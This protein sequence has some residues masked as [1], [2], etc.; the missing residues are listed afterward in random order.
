MAEDA[1]RLAEAAQEVTDRLTEIASAAET[2]AASGAAAD[3][4][5]LDWV[6][7]TASLDPSNISGMAAAS[8]A[9]ADAAVNADAAF[10]DWATSTAA[11]A[12]GV[13]SVDELA[14]AT[15]QAEAAAASAADAQSGLNEATQ[16][17]ADAAN[18]ASNSW[19]EL[20]N[21]LGD[22][23]AAT[24]VVAGEL[25]EL[26]D[27]VGEHLV[28]AFNK[29]K[30]AIEG[31]S[32]AMVAAGAAAGILSVAIVAAAGASVVLASS[33]E[34]A[35]VN[36]Q[37]FGDVGEEEA[38]RV[39][40][41]LLEMGSNSEFS[42]QQLMNALVP[43]SGRLEVLTGHVLSVADA[44]KLM[45]S[46]S[47]LAEASQ[48]DLGTATGSLV[49]VLQAYGMGLGDAARAS[50]V[51]FNTSRF[52]GIEIGTLASQVELMHA[53]LGAASPSLED[54]GALMID[55]TAHGIEG[56]RAMRAVTSAVGNLIHPSAEA[57]AT[58]K[59]L[60]LTVFDAEGKFVGIQSILT[61]LGPIF[62]NMTAQQRAQAESM[63]FGAQAGSMLDGVLVSGADAFEKYAGMASEAGTASAAAARD[64]ETLSVQLEILK[65]DLVATATEIGQKFL[66]AVSLIVSGLRPML[67]FFKNNEEASTAL[68]IV[69][70]GILVAGLLAGAVAFYAIAGA[71][72]VAFIAENAA[73]LGIPIAIALVVAALYL[74]VQNWDSVWAAMKAAP[75]AV[76]NWFK[77]NWPLILT[78]IM[79]PFAGA[80]TLLQ[81]HWGAAFDLLP[82][83]VQ[84]FAIHVGNI[85]D[86]MIAGIETAIEAMVHVIGAALSPVSDF[87]HTITGGTI[88]INTGPLEN[89]ALT[90]SNIG[91]AL[92]THQTAGDT[93]SG[94]MAEQ[95]MNSQEAQNKRFAEYMAS[96]FAQKTGAGGP[97]SGGGGYEWQPPG[98]GGG[99]GGPSAE[100]MLAEQNLRE[101]ESAFQEFAA[102]TGGTREDF[103]AYIQ[104]AQDRAA[105]ETNLITTNL[106]LN[107]AQK[108]AGDS[109]FMLSSIL[110]KFTQDQLDLAK[111]AQAAGIA[112]GAAQLEAA[113][114][115]YQLRK[116]LV[117]IAEDMVRTGNTIEEEMVKIQK[118]I[119]DNIRSAG[120]AALSAPTRESAQAALAIDTLQLRRDKLSR[121][122]DP[123]IARLQQQLAGATGDERDSIQKH[124]DALK[125][126][127]T[128]I[129]N[130]IQTL[131]DEDKIR[132]DN[133][134]IMKDKL[135]LADQGL[136]TDAQQAQA[137]ALYT[138][139][140]SQATSTL[141]FLTLQM[142][143]Q[144]EDIQRMNA[145]FAGGHGEDFMRWITGGQQGASP[146]APSTGTGAG[147]GA[148]APSEDDL[149][150][151]REAINGG[152]ADDFLKWIHAAHDGGV[153]NSGGLYNTKPGEA[154]V[155]LDSPT[156]SRMFGEGSGSGGGTVVNVSIENHITGDSD[157]SQK[158]MEKFADVLVERQ[159]QDLVQW[160]S[161]GTL[162]P[163]GA[164]D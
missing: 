33:Y 136:Q 155:P 67:E 96:L 114:S 23:G 40:D 52:T 122:L 46:A 138:I 48:S 77:D 30:E 158:A 36:L 93:Y 26:A 73:L 101:L 123:Q 18:Q 99:G 25:G 142:G 127:Y 94:L 133:V 37:N 145:A 104:V 121:E 20:G 110:L 149:R 44:E 100:Q 8:D 43:V 53:R 124:I 79:S 74:L 13:S 130:Q 54:L 15:G 62:Q 35:I 1:T 3:A 32:G 132:Q 135:I 109:T 139:A 51:L 63:L 115:G 97:T 42:A 105:I 84:D 38:N 137:A 153:T 76:F 70:G 65:N 5:F 159:Q 98:G 154:L 22:A 90:R 161:T 95:Q 134:K 34:D 89:F 6:T 157:M 160:R 103:L 2:A 88:D 117:E 85:V 78:F 47:D 28:E 9:A 152:H 75:E 143:Q 17:G 58:I 24:L 61:Q 111:R 107:V 113:D 150:R 68:A 31:E 14:S 146:V 41:A 72:V 86:T 69:V 128:A 119:V 120:N 27:Q 71:A 56:S 118:A 55:L 12:A 29:A 57:Q 162:P 164:F 108:E 151:M 11:L 39:G 163:T 50:D 144:S 102:V 59:S 10:V 116:A 80:L 45:A 126:Q 140:L 19:G 156:G 125:A 49:G 60:G 91:G 106:A 64:E 81:Q 21:I 87:I 129:D 112:L 7:T 4:T 83:P 141:N 148:P 66:P 92:Q 82:R 16:G 131:R 147:P